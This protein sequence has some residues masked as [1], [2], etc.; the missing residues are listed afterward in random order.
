MKKIKGLQRKR[1]Y[2]CCICLKTIWEYPGL[3]VNKNEMW[4]ENCQHCKDGDKVD[5]A[6]VEL[7]NSWFADFGNDNYKTSPVR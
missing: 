7:F 2:S 4:C 3:V 5:C 1:R 6:S